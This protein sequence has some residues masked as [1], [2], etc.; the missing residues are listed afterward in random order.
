MRGAGLTIG[1]FGALEALLHHGPLCQ[2]ELGE[3]LL[4]SD[5]NTAVVVGNLL[6]RGL[7]QRTRRHDD[8]RYQMVALSETGRRLITDI[9]PRHVAGLVREMRMLSRDELDALGRLCRRLG[10]A[11]D[12]P[13]GG[14]RWS[15]RHASDRYSGTKRAASRL[16]TTMRAI[17]SSRTSSRW[18]PDPSRTR[19]S[20][21]ARIS[22]T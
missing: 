19:R 6:R 16:S 8:K 21:S 7:V 11:D 15:T 13:K 1:Q 2:R 14:E 9:F 12:A 22:S 17:T 18:H 20:P 10:L 4:R 3:K 5:A